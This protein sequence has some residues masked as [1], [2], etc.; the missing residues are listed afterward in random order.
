M[1]T[2]YYPGV[3]CGMNYTRM[4]HSWANPDI[5]TLHHSYGVVADGNI[6]N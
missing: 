5:P 3:T 6:A 1:A 4:L 2:A